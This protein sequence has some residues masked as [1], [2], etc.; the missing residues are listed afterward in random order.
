MLFKNR[1]LNVQ[2]IK[3][4]SVTDMYNSKCLKVYTWLPTCIS[5]ETSFQKPE[6][7]T[8]NGTEDQ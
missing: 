3:T 1:Y 2:A 5:I 8:D 6:N 7:G 4:K